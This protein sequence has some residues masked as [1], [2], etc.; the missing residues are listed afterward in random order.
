M[1]QRRKSRKKEPTIQGLIRQEYCWEAFAQFQRHVSNGATAAPESQGV[2]VYSMFIICSL[3]NLT[4]M[5]LR[6]GI[7]ANAMQTGPRLPLHRQPPIALQPPLK[8]PYDGVTKHI[9]DRNA[10]TRFFLTEKMGKDL[11]LVCSV[12]CSRILHTL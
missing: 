8:Q 12:C 7:L 11:C 5:C 2:T 4:L 10:Q 6:R 9:L 3:R 1:T